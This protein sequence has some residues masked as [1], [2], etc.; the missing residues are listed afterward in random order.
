MIDMIVLMRSLG[1]GLLKGK[2]GRVNNG[3]AGLMVLEIVAPIADRSLQLMALVVKF[4]T[5]RQKSE[6]C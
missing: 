3:Q 6:V 2:H 4:Y 5:L 1:Y